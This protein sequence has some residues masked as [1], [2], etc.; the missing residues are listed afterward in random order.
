M[1]TTGSVLPM[2]S[3]PAILSPMQQTASRESID[4]IGLSFI[5]D[6]TPL[7]EALKRTTHLAIMAHQDDIEI[8]A[9]HG[10]AEAC[11]NADH[12]FTAVVV[13][14]GRNSP[15]SG[16]FANV[17]PDE[18]VEIRA[19]EQT[20]AARLGRYNALIQMQVPSGELSSPAVSRQL[21]T[22]IESCPSAQTLYTH[23]PFDRHRTHRR[24][25][26]EVANA[27]GSLST[28]SFERIYGAEVWGKLDW[29]PSRF[30]HSLDVSYHPKLAAD[31]LAVFA[32]QID[33]GKRYDLA[34]MGLRLSNATYSESHAV[35]ES[36]A[37]SY[38]LDMTDALRNHPNG[39]KRLVDEVMKAFSNEKHKAWEEIE[40]L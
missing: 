30:R 4:Q 16:R 20:K 17:S 1:K 26:H 8:G 36:A 22:I 5:P 23:N 12:H 35:D 21:A 38:A 33:G 37:V 29:L 7:R 10:I 32:S 24:V 34:E 15:R 2:S 9:Y 3:P 13:T 39:L 27:I 11:Q 19:E 25:L 6:G 28:L 18:M 40:T 14:D 31:L